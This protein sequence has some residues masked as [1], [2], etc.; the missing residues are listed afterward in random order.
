MPGL[1]PVV[2]GV[3]PEGGKGEVVVEGGKSTAIQLYAHRYT[4][5]Q[6]YVIKELICFTCIIVGMFIIPVDLQAVCSSGYKTTW[7]LHTDCN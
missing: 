1:P 6:L 5:V 7:R 2:V 3:A 4:A